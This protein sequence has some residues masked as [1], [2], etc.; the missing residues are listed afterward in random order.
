VVIPTTGFTT[1]VPALAPGVYQVRV[2]GRTASG[3]FV[4]TF[5]DALAVT[6]Q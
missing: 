5:S 4:G 3:A 2:L 6:I 1:L